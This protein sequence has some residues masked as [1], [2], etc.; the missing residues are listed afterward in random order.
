MAYV[1][2]K[3]SYNGSFDKIS[4]SPTTFSTVTE[5][6]LISIWLPF[7]WGIEALFIKKISEK[8]NNDRLFKVEKA[9]KI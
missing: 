2:L 6:V 7:L 5:L 3:K 1:G 4:R 9:K 8:F